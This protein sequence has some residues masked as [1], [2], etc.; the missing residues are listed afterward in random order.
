MEWCP[1]TAACN[2]NYCDVGENIVRGDDI[3]VS[4]TFFAGLRMV[5]DDLCR[6]PQMCN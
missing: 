3:F 1:Q 6:N 2:E 5:S 4:Y